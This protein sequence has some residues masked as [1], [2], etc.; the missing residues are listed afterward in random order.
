MTLPKVS[1]PR[2]K[3]QPDKVLTPS[4]QS[5]MDA[6]LRIGWKKVEN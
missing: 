2:G 3:G 1:Y 5:E 4:S 6:L